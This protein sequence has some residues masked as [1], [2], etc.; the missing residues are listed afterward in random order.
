MKIRT[1]FVTNSSSSSFIL[2]RKGELTDKQKEIIVQ[3][4]LKNFLGEKDLT[5]EN[6]E[7]EIQNYFE[8]QYIDEE[9]QEA[10][11]KALKEGKS[12]YSGWVSFED[13]DNY[14]YMLE[15]LWEQ[16]EEADGSNFK[17]IDSDLSY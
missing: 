8:E 9:Q 2:A 12:I 10:I 11:V 6:T 13:D 1:D 17:A 16:L 15:E 7:E 4:A 5:P 3:F 14:A